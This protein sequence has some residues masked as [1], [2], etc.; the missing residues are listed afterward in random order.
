MKINFFEKVRCQEAAGAE[1]VPTWAPKRV[2]NGAPKRAKTE[3]KKKEEKR[4]EEKRGLER[5]SE[6]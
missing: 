5:F 6:V 3:Q 1:L 2:Q 4:S